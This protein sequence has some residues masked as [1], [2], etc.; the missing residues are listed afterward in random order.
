MAVAFFVPG[1]E[2]EQVGGRFA[3]QVELVVLEIPGGEGVQGV[4]GQFAPVDAL[5][6]GPVVKFQGVPHLKTGQEVTMVER[7][8][9]PKLFRLGRCLQ[10]GVVADE[11]VK[12]GHIEN[13]GLG[14]V[15]FD[16]IPADVQ[17]GFE[18]FA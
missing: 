16:G 7:G 4:Q 18:Q 5:G 10:R 2:A 6:D 11:P 9:A 12:L 15:K 8:R 3:S 1:V 13:I 17:V 14:G